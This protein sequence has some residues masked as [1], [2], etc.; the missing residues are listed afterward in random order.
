MYNPWNTSSL[1]KLNLLACFLC[2]KCSIEIK[3]VLKLFSFNSGWDT[4]IKTV[5]CF[6]SS[7]FESLHSRLW[8]KNRTEVT[9]KVMCMAV[10]VLEKLTTSLEGFH[11]PPAV[12]I[13]PP[14]DWREE[15]M[16]GLVHYAARHTH[17]PRLQ[18]SPHTHTHF[19]VNNTTADPD[20]GL[21]IL[22][23]HNHLPP[24]NLSN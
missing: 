12:A 19:S 13:N 10:D 14:C 5:W 4:L 21:M 1:S 3:I 22:V 11:S 16:R 17:T 8:C 9:I 20:S 15:V 23:C 2:R 18:T 6:L 24:V 7:T